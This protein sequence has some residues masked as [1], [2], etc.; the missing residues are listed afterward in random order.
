MMI[1]SLAACSNPIKQIEVSTKPVAKPTLTLPSVDELNM[2]EVKWVVINEDNIETPRFIINPYHSNEVFASNIIPSWQTGEE[3]SLFRQYVPD[4]QL[5]DSAATAEDGFGYE[6]TFIEQIDS[7]PMLNSDIAMIT[8][9]LTSEGILKQIN[10]QREDIPAH[11]EARLFSDRTSVAANIALREK[12][13][14]SLDLMGTTCF[15]PGSLVYIDPLPLDLGYSDRK[16]DNSLARSLG[17]G[18]MYRVVNLTSNINFEANGATWET[19]VNTKWESFGDG[20]DGTSAVAQVEADAGVCAAREA[21]VE[22]AQQA[23]VG[24]RMAQARFYERQA[25][26]QS[27]AFYV[28]PAEGARSTDVVP[29]G[30]ASIR[31]PE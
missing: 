7:N 5:K 13:N 27:S 14:T 19:K 25:E 8:F 2:R 21:R 4:S 3:K 28:D 24:D 22:R 10:F 29:L 12:Y 17:L 18:G 23:L 1:I 15:R 16:E 26:E 20:D 30:G 11:A 31:V 9:G 6:T